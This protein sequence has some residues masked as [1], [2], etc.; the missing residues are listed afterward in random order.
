MNKYYKLLINSSAVTKKQTNQQ[1]NKKKMNICTL[2]YSLSLRNISKTKTKQTNKEIVPFSCAYGVSPKTKQQTK[3][4][5]E[6]TTQS[7]NTPKT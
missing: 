7:R 6:Q 1:K 5:F 2:G 4:Y 3:T